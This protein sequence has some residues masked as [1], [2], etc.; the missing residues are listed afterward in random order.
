M[1][2]LHQR[3]QTVDLGFTGK[4]F[5]EDAPQSQRVITKLFPH[6]LFSKRRRIT[7][8]EDQVDH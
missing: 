3:Q 5:R 7:F 6:P 2:E 1:L 4:K 8:V